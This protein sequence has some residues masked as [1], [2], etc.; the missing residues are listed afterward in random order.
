MKTNEVSAEQIAGWKKKY[1][2]I[3]QFTY[4]NSEGKELICYLRNPTMNDVGLA[5][6]NARKNPANFGKTIITT[7]WLAGDDE[8]KE[9]DDALFSISEELDS[10][11][12]DGQTVVKNL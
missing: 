8:I 11:I 5:T 6:T 10:L 1:K 7:C 3:K 12:K 9:N 2:R 4:T